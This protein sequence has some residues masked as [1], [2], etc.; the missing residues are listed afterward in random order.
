MTRR[1]RL[2]VYGLVRTGQGQRAHGPDSSDTSGVVQKWNVRCET[3]G[4]GGQSGG[5]GKGRSGMG[6][7]VWA[8]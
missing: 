7:Q 6:C 3:R 5:V 2:E 4:W 8:E 1:V